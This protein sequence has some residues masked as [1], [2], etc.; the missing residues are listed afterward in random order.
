MVIVKLVGT[1]LFCSHFA[2]LALDFRL[3]DARF[4]G[5]TDDLL[6][7]V[8]LILTNE[9]HARS[10]KEGCWTD[11]ELVQGSKAKYVKKIFPAAMGLG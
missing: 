9:F 10:V 6:I 7:L 1:D 8:F 2:F 3:F 4:R 5:S 11:A